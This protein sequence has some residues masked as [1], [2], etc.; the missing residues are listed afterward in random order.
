MMKVSQAFQPCHRTS[1]IR[2]LCLFTLVLLTTLVAMGLLTS[3]FETNGL[4]ALELSLLLLYAILFS[5]ICFSFWTALVGFFVLFT[6]RDRCQISASIRDIPAKTPLQ[7]RTALVMP[8]YNEDPQR[9]F[10]GLRAI[11]TSLMQTKQQQHFDIFILSDTRLPEVWVEEELH[12]QALQKSLDGKMRVFYRNRLHNS[13]RKVGNIKDFCAQWGDYYDFMIVLDADSLMSGDTLVK[14]TRIME[15]NPKV[16]L[17]Q[18]PPQSVNRESLFARIQQF[19]GNV[20]NPIFT[21]GLNFWQLDEGNY[22]GHNA[23]IRVKAFV[24]HCGLPKLS[25]REPFGGEI[26]SHD[27]IEAALLR[28]AGWQVWLAYD[29]DGSYEEIPPTLIDYARRDRRWCQGN[30]QHTRLL[31]AQG[32][33][34]IN[35]LHLLMGIM[36]YLASPLWLVFLI[37][38]GI[39]AY[40][41][42][43]MTPVYFWGETLFPNWPASYR[44]EMTTVLIVTLLILFLPKLLALILVLKDRARLSL[45]G[46]AVPLISG[47]VLETVSSMLLAP[48]MMLFQTQF[49]LA[50]LLRRNINWMSQNR[51]DHHTRIGEALLVHGWHMVLGIGVGVFAYRYVPDFFWWLTP[52][53]AGLVLSIPLSII[54]SYASLGH[55]AR[56]LKLFLIPT[57]MQPPDLLQDLRYWLHVE[58]HVVPAHDN[59]FIQV[60]AEP[61]VNALHLALLPAHASA[62]DKRYR[63]YLQGLVYQ[64]LEEGINSLSASE[65]RAL[66]LDRET[67]LQLHTLLWGLP[68]MAG[69]LGQLSAKELP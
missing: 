56:Q 11:A 5:W 60:L 53:L 29:M 51:A 10:A 49:V 24:A 61:K 16:A 66:L 41:K 3:V 43:Q 32:F 54:L 39:D 62:P 37:V 44:I 1:L 9:V 34:P 48:I 30:L 28:R 42:E 22:W 65:R 47:V 2:R 18:V 7:S 46:G 63:H 31:F 69:S 14:M 25:G 6:Q 8:I 27:F 57:E 59:R 15:H 19:A 13:E 58:Q 45:Y 23:I 68:A 21:A 67:V 26:F 38:T 55:W 35:R 17:V 33:H 20:Y 50:I 52:V 4:T 40:W 12:W 36:S 64:L